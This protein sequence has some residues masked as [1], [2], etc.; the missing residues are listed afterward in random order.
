MGLQVVG[1]GFGRTGTLSLKG[2]LEQLGFGPCYH[3]MEVQHHVE[4]VAEWR[5]VEQGANVDW[6]QLFEGYQATVDWPSCNYWEQQLAHYPQA[7]VILSQRDAAGW[8]KSVMNTIYPVTVENWAR[9]QAAAK[10][11]GELDVQAE[12]RYRMAMELIWDGVFHGKVED[13]NYACQ[14]FE[15]HNR[16]V[17]ALVPAAQLLVYEPGDGWEP[18]CEFLNCPVPDAPYPKV[19]STADFQRFVRGQ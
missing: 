4:H 3:M 10:I 13:A 8:H 14:V 9:T 5:A 2:A 12:A 17:K 6:D 7:K 11:S 18:L 16:R 15:A 19:N 1:A